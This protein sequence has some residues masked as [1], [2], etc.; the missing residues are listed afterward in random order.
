[1]QIDP[2]ALR[3]HFA[4]LSDEALIAVDR[5]DLIEMAQKCYD[6]ELVRRRVAPQRQ[7]ES[8]AEVVDPA[9]PSDHPGEGPDAK[10]ALVIDSEVDPDWLDEA[11]CACTFANYPGS[12]SAS[13]AAHAR[14][15]LEAVGIPCHI[16]VREI[17]PPSAD[18]PP[19][20][21]YCLM[22]PGALNLQATGVLDVQIFNSTLEADWRTLLEALSDEELLALNSDIYLRR[23]S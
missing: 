15:V 22:V 5:T 16:S 13:E 17:D 20:S 23:T 8:L 7:A 11:A 1:M 6:A 10:R 4:S 9:T 12:P 2:E 21:E 3:R 18:P 14:D 19:R